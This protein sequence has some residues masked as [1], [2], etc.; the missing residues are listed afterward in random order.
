[1]N[2]TLAFL[3]ILGLAGCSKAPV[4]APEPRS[5]AI[6]GTPKTL[7][8]VTLP[9]GSKALA[10]VVR[11]PAHPASYK[12]L[13]YCDYPLGY[14]GP[15]APGHCY[16]DGTGCTGPAINTGGYVSA[17]LNGDPDGTPIH[18]KALDPDTGDNVKEGDPD[19]TSNSRSAGDPT[20]DD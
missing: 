14:A 15:P 20:A 4:T 7:A 11:D 13:Y 1:M 3:A 10:W 6:M 16:T 18:V 17:P 19:D 2:R 8:T 12:I 9:D 5:E